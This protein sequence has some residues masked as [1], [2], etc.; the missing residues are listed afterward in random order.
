MEAEQVRHILATSN[1]RAFKLVIAGGK[2]Y[3][4]PHPDYVH[5]HP[6]QRYLT[7][8]TSDKGWQ[9]D[10]VDLE[11]VCSIEGLGYAEFAGSKV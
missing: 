10:V 7:V 1:G 5:I 3:D 2:T 8:F 9:Y 6:S 11:H 4:T